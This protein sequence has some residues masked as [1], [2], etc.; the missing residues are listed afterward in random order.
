MATPTSNTVGYTVISTSGLSQQVQ[1]LL[2]GTK[3]GGGLG[4]G[5]A[6]TYSFPT[7]AAHSFWAPSYSGDNEYTNMNVL[8]AVER[9]ACQQALTVWANSANITFSKLSDNQTTCGEIRFAISD[10][11]NSGFYAHAYYP[12]GTPAAGDVWFSNQWNS[13]ATASV[14]PGT[15]AFTTILHELGHALGL[16]HPF[17]GSPNLDAAHDN[18]F[19]TIMSYDVKENSPVSSV[20]ADFYPT[21]PQ[22]YD[23]LAMET[24]YGQSPTANPGN[25]K[26]VFY[27]T[28]HYW[29]TINDVSGRDTII[30]KSSTGGRIDLSDA[31]FSQLGLPIHFGDGTTS[32]DTV[33]L[34]PF[35]TIENATGGNGG[36][37]IFGSDGRNVLNGGA[38]NDSIEGE[39][40][41]DILNGGAGR[42]TFVYAGAADSAGAR[43]DTINGF[44]AAQ[45]ALDVWKN[46]ASIDHR[47]HTGS[48]SAAGF[49]QDL[50]HTL[51]AGR[52][53]AHSALLYTAAKGDE[54]GKLFLIV[55]PTGTAGYGA[56]RDL[57]ILLES[58]TGLDHFGT[59]NFT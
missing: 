13:D 45:D 17:D 40:G 27:G 25:T 21:T 49:D 28:Q 24:L 1:A 57:V 12:G 54:A 51:G 30:Y 33:A 6:L 20:S 2:S 43:F 46:I 26:Y 5:V 4:T 52:L 38:G 50:A 36:D 18:F 29:Q 9:S 56:G 11:G 3:W 42:D 19:Y 44:D 7:S 41:A 48:L 37:T 32:Y 15:Y 16:K 39:K 55:N 59:H 14:A 34:G 47:L 31:T 8:N 53:A 22:Y 10:L 23:L 35:T 58:A